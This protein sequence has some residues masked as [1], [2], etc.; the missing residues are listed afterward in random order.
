MLQGVDFSKDDGFWDPSEE[1]EDDNE[2]RG[3][4]PLSLPTSIPGPVGGTIAKT[5]VPSSPQMSLY[6]L[7][8]RC[9]NGRP[10][11]E[12]RSWS[13]PLLHM[14]CCRKGVPLELVKMLL[15]KD[16][17][18]ASRSVSLESTKSVYC[19]TKG[20]TVR[21]LVK[22]QYAYPLNLAIKYK[23]SPEVLA[24]LIDA[25]PSS[26]LEQRDGQMRENSLAILLR[27]NPREFDTLT[28]IL[29]SNFKLASLRADRHDNTPL[30]LAVGATTTGGAS[31]DVVRFL[32]ALWPESLKITNFHGKKPL[33]VLCQRSASVIES[34]PVATYLWEEERKLLF[35]TK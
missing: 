11:G 28:K 2:L 12:R 32:Y 4:P 26:V 3:Y 23:V 1:D 9:H 20:V 19:P 18:A 13:E 22:E 21:K 5:I 31:L 35:N 29:H 7:A 17:G 27:H 6:S 25:T 15:V 24:A 14:V 16:P 34:E 30:H 33:E 10:G 8:S